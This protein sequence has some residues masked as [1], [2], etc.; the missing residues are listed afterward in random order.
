M[1][2]RRS[3]C[4]A[5]AELPNTRCKRPRSILRRRKKPC[6]CWQDRRPGQRYSDWPMSSSPEIGRRS[7][8][9]EPPERPQGCITA[10]DSLGAIEYRVKEATGEMRFSRRDFVKLSGAT[11][12]GL[13]LSSRTTAVALAQRIRPFP[14]HKPISEAATICPYCSCGC[15]LIVATDDEGHIINTEGDPENPQNRGVLDPKS[16]SVTQ[17]SQSPLRL[18]KPLYRAPG[19]AD[20]EE[21]DWDWTITEVAKRIKAT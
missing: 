21:K 18:R 20:F 7:P 5:I 12:G 16:I 8:A 17:L 11:V 1:R 4:F 14:L 15:G 3:N 13:L 6:R 10:L 9:A 19:K 2:L